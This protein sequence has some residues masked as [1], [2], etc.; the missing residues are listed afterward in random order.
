MNANDD[1]KAE[2]SSTT[3]DLQS[4]FAASY[5]PTR[6]HQSSLLQRLTLPTGRPAP[7]I[8]RGFL[9]VLV[10]ELNRT[11]KPMRIMLWL[12]LMLFPVLLLTTAQSL[13][14]MPRTEVYA[15]RHLFIVAAIQFV[16]LPQVVTVLCMLLWA[17]PIVNAE[18]EGQTWIYSVVRP[19][20]RRAMLLGKYVVAVLWTGSCTTCSAVVSTAVASSF[21]VANVW[22]ACQEIVLVNWISAASYGALMLTLGTLFQRRSMVF[23]FAYAAGVEAVLGSMPAIINRFTISYRLRSLA[24][25]WLKVDFKQLPD[26]FGFLWEA[27]TKTHLS[28][29]ALATLGLLGFTLWRIERSQYRFQ[30]EF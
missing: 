20:G 30:S 27:A 10:F 5:S 15:D 23:A 24:M 19:G 1:S 11:L 26:E 21:G 14:R 2:T 8:W 13:I 12:G 16:L 9:G 4:Q 3:H 25:E 18:L 6:N 22:P 17:V 7:S 29:L 28:I